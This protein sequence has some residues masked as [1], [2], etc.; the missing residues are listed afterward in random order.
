MLISIT[1]FSCMSLHAKNIADNRAIFSPAPTDQRQN[2]TAMIR[3]LTK[4]DV[5]K[6]EQTLGI[7]LYTAL[8]ELNE[9]A[10]EAAE[11]EAKYNK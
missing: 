11:I 10:R 1:L 8:T 6:Q 3:A 7:D 9:L 2:M 5:T 4:G